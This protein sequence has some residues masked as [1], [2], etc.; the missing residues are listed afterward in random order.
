MKCEKFTVLSRN[1][2]KTR[3]S[4]DT[5]EYIHFFMPI[6]FSSRNQPALQS[7]PKDR[8]SNSFIKYNCKCVDDDWQLDLAIY[9][10]FLKLRENIYTSNGLIKRDQPP[11]SLISLRVFTRDTV[12]DLCMSIFAKRNFA[13][14][15]H[16]REQQ[17][18]SV[19]AAKAVASSII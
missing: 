18:E 10:V 4:L 12:Y 19:V 11:A 6:I 2:R 17:V 7:S 14:E 1:R 16:I 13:T 15:K 3:D 9:A 8:G 5:E